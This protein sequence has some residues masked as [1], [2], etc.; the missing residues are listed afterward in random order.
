MSVTTFSFKMKNSCSW[1]PYFPIPYIFMRLHC[2]LYAWH[3]NKI[4]QIWHMYRNV[5]AS[6]PHS[7]GDVLS[8]TFLKWL[9]FGGKSKNLLIKPSFPVTTKI[10]QIFQNLECNLGFGK[11]HVL[12]SML[13]TLWRVPFLPGCIFPTRELW[14]S[15]MTPDMAR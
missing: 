2:T 9:P 4:P 12:R 7:E 6:A 3:M 14:P 13:I 8:W 10:N 1:I 15:L 5:T 11:S